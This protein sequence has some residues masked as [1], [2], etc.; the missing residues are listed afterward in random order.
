M[1]VV[2]GSSL[3]VR[4]LHICSAPL[5]AL[6]HSRAWLLGCEASTDR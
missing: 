1:S 4:D 2:A 5:L 6:C 3:D